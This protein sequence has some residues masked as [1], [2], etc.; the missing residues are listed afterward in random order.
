MAPNTPGQKPATTKPEKNVPDEPEEEPV[1]HED[2]Q[3]RA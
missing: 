3:A 2:E 1:D